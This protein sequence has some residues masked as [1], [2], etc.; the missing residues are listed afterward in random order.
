MKVQPCTSCRLVQRRGLLCQS[1]SIENCD[2]LLLGCVAHSFTKQLNHVDVHLAIGMDDKPVFPSNESRLQS[3]ELSRFFLPEKQPAL[4][5][6]DCKSLYD[7][8]NKELSVPLSTEQRLVMV[9]DPA[10]SRKS[11]MDWFLI[12]I[13]ARYQIA[14]CMQTSKKKYC[15]T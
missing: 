5:S 13:D 4:L 14:D 1:P 11:K 2:V 9:L 7:S 12:W 10:K 3:G 6:T 8:I 15:N